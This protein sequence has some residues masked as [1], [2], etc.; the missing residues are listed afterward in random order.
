MKLIDIIHNIDDL[1]DAE[2]IVTGESGAP[3]AEAC[4]TIFVVRPWSPQS[5][6]IV[7]PIP[8]NSTGSPIIV[9]E[10]EMQYFLEVFV[11][12]QFFK[13]RNISL[14]MRADP[15]KLKELIDYAQGKTS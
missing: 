1:P 2:L 6:A 9:G 13:S 3:E 8:A 4:L 10:H 5:E 12:K 14:E 15:A 11:A 7:V